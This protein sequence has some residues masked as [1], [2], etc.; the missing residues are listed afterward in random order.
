MSKIFFKNEKQFEKKEGKNRHI[1]ASLRTP[2]LPSKLSQRIIVSQ[3]KIDH[4]RPV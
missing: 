2:Y 1:A 3:E 4:D